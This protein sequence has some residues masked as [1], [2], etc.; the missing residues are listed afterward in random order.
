MGKELRGLDEGL[1]GQSVSQVRRWQVG[2][3]GAGPSRQGRQGRFLEEN[4]G[5]R[6]REMIEENGR[7]YLEIKTMEL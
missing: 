7:P 2:R 1:V 5:G 6:E 4:R 3:A